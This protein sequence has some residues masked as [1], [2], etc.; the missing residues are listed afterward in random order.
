MIW[1]GTSLWHLRRWYLSRGFQSQLF[2]DH[3]WRRPKLNLETPI[4]TLWW[5]EEE[6]GS[7]EIQETRPKSSKKDLDS[8][9]NARWGKQEVKWPGIIVSWKNNCHFKVNFL[10]T[11]DRMVT[12][13]L[14]EG[15]SDLED[16]CDKNEFKIQFR[17]RIFNRNQWVWVQKFGGEWARRNHKQ[18]SHRC[19][20][21]Y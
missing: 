16:S 15:T 6:L 11:G 2:E 19:A 13:A 18:L 5:I 12:Q 3:R 1:N 14:R 20:A 10:E 21:I 4:A 8:D 9:L 7:G 17:G